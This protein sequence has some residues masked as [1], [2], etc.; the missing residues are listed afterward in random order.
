[1]GFRFRYNQK[2]PIAFAFF[3][4]KGFQDHIM[5]EI[6]H[7]PISQAE[8]IARFQKGNGGDRP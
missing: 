2:F 6:P 3:I 8:L 1:M 5:K 7:F 4:L